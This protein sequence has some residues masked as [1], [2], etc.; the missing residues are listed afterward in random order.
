MQKN[1]PGNY[2]AGAKQLH[3]FLIPTLEAGY[4][5][6]HK[7]TDM[8]KNVAMALIASVMLFSSCQKELG[9][10]TVVGGNI[11][12]DTM[13]ANCRWYFLNVKFGDRVRKVYVDEKTYRSYYNGSQICF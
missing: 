9:C 4:T 7:H 5:Y 3:G 11:E 12:C 10:G 6:T 8:R 13:V 1:I 2:S